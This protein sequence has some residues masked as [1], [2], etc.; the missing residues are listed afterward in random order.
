MQT[1]NKEFVRSLFELLLLIDTRKLS[2]PLAISWRPALVGEPTAIVA[3]VDEHNFKEWAQLIDES[4]PVVIEHGDE[5]HIHVEGEMQ[6]GRR[7]MIVAVSHSTAQ[8]VSA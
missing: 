7:L 8:P 4:E 3:Q 2:T 5:L 1:H 6:S